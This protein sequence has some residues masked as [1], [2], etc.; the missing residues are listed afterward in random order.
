MGYRYDALTKIY[1]RTGGAWVA[2][3]QTKD[4]WVYS[5]GFWQKVFKVYRK[6]GGVWVLLLHSDKYAPTAAP[7]ATIASSAG[8]GGTRKATVTWTESAPC[9]LAP[10]G[11]YDLY[12]FF[13]NITDPTKNDSAIIAAGR[14]GGGSQIFINNALGDQCYADLSYQEPGVGGYAGPVF[15][16][17]TITM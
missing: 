15:T 14:V 6:S 9:P 10:A 7:T 4:I 12:I 16:T 3:S 2:Q 13:Y 8:G 5:G 11:N 1:I 17:T